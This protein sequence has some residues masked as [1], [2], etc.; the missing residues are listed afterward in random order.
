MLLAGGE[1]ATAVAAVGD[2]DLRA[3]L[4][5]AAAL[6]ASLVPPPV[7]V[8]FEARLGA[9]LAEATRSRRGALHSPARILVMGAISSAAVGV[10][11]TAFAFWRSNRRQARLVQRLGR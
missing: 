11:V 1:P 4:E 6:R 8:R 2:P 7:G 5:A 10:G 3:P 9:R